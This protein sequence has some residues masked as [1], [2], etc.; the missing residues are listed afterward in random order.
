MVDGAAMTIC[1][2]VIASMV[3]PLLAHV[4]VARG[5]NVGDV[6][7]EIQIERTVYISPDWCTDAEIGKAYPA[8]I[9]KGRTTVWLRVGQGVCRYHIVDTRPFLRH[10]PFAMIKRGRLTIVF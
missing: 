5:K 6:M 4:D 8:Q 9:D 1:V 3:Y 10:T 7:T 2:L